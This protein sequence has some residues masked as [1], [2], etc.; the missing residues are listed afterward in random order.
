MV[1]SIY[2][3]RKS[4]FMAAITAICIVSS[5]FV[6]MTRQL[7]DV[8]D[9]GVFLTLNGLLVGHEG[10]QQLFA[11]L[12]SRYADWMFEG[13]VISVYLIH[14]IFKGPV[15]RKERIFQMIFLL[16]YVAAIQIFVNKILCFKILEISRLSPSL[17]LPVSVD[18]SV[19]PLPNN[20]TFSY[21]S[22]PADHALSLFMAAFFAWS[23][24]RRPIAVGCTIFYTFL[25][26]PRLMSG[27]H[28]FS[29]VLFSGI[30]FA[31]IA[32]SLVMMTPLYSLLHRKIVGNKN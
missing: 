1:Y 10:W 17:V 6:P 8:V 31:A 27:A 24:F 9:S 23:H 11:W 4:F 18:L 16:L 13:I 20:K 19:F 2:M 15:S 5:W 14:C 30:G 28:W 12:N 29:D 26:L 3:T 21:N 25:V 7:W 22:F 32:W